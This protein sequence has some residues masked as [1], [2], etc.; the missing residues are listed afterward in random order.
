MTNPFEQNENLHWITFN[1]INTLV[2][3]VSAAT[4]EGVEVKNLKIEERKIKS[5]NKQQ[6]EKTKCKTLVVWFI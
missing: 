1:L 6:L 5:N 2:E 3:V 4:H